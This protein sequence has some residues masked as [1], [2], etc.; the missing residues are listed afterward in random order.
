AASSATNTDGEEANPRTGAGRPWPVESKRATG[1]RTPRLHRPFWLPRAGNTARRRGGSP[2]SAPQRRWSD[3]QARGPEPTSP[4]T[5]L[6]S[7]LPAPDQ[8]LHGISH[9]PPAGTGFSW[10]CAIIT[11]RIGELRVPTTAD[12]RHDATLR[13]APGWATIQGEGK[14]DVTCISRLRG[15]AASRTCT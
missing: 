13:G 3:R 11:V 8:G 10:P 1:R 5:R 2:A 15:E 4:S 14:G 6:A 9:G 7:S 12:T